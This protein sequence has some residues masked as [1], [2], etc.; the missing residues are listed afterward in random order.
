MII[1]HTG[2]ICVAEEKV[3]VV[4]REPLVNLLNFQAQTDL[5]L[6]YQQITINI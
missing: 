3:D 2:M 6:N 4:Q 5:I 1:S